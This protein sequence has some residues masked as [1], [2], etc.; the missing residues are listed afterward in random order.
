MV[1]QFTDHHLNASLVFMCTAWI[2]RRFK[3]DT[4]A[5]SSLEQ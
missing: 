3:G 2:A 1:T 5:Q 4:C